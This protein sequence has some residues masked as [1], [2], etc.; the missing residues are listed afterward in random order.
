MESAPE[1]G[2]T[3]AVRVA[4]ARTGV[5]EPSPRAL[6]LGRWWSAG[7]EDATEPPPGL[8]RAVVDY[9]AAPSRRSTRGAIRA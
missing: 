5:C 4:S 1:P 6:D 8:R 9:V 2:I 7:L 3:E